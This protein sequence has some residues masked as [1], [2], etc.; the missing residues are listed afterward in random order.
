MVVRVWPLAWMRVGDTWMLLATWRLS[1]TMSL[2]IRSHRRLRFRPGEFSLVGWRKAGC[3]GAHTALWINDCSH[4]RSVAP[5][6]LEPR[7]EQPQPQLG[8]ADSDSRSQRISHVMYCLHAG[9]LSRRITRHFITQF[10]SHTTDTMTHGGK[11]SRQ[12][13]SSEQLRLWPRS[14]LWRR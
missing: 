1:I 6:A 7:T 14:V 12:R 5:F 11:E 9:I 3:F 10:L 2:Q 8:S 13:N 4:L